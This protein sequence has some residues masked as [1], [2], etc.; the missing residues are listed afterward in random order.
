MEDFDK[1]WTGNKKSTYAQLGASNHVDHDRAEHDFYST[2]PKALEIFLN[3]IKD[4]KRFKLDNN[5]WECACGDGALS[6]VLEERGFNVRSTDLIDRDYGQGGFDFLTSMQKFD[7]DILTNP[8]YKY[9][10]EFVKKGLSLV[11]KKK[12]VVMFLKIQ[13]LEGLE[14]YE[15][16]KKNPPKYVYVHSSRVN[17]YLNGIIPEKPS[18]SASCYCWYVWEKGYKGEPRVRWIKDEKL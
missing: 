10:L 3:A 13:F 8:P 5:I 11:P 18:T 9:A 1:D 14:R 7:G 16:F 17:C 12:H 6:K 4:D 2:D 15:F